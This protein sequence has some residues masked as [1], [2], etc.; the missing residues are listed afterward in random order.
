M[1]SRPKDAL[2]IDCIGLQAIGFANFV[3]ETDTTNN[4]SELTAGILVETEQLL[5]A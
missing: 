2:A 5:W 3:I 4:W 1:E